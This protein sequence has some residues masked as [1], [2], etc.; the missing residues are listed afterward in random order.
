MSTLT[1]GQILDYLRSRE[2][3]MASLLQEIMAIES[4]TTNKAAVDQL[5]AFLAQH[6]RGMGAAVEILPQVS[7]GDVIRATWNAGDGGIL[8]LCH[9]DTVWD[10]GTI[11]AD[12][13][14]TED[15]RIYGP[16]S[17]D[18]KG[19]IVVTLGAIEALQALGG[20]PDTPITL[21]INTDEET[22]SEASAPI[23]EAEARRHRVVF[24]MEPAEDGAYKTSR[25]GMSQYQ[26]HI[27]GRATH[28]GANH[29]EG[30]NAI[31]ELAR[32]ILTI[33]GFTDYAAGT[34]TNVGI[35]QGGTRSNVVPA[36]A[37]A[38]V[39]SR[40]TSQARQQELDAKMRALKPHHPEAQIE[41]TGGIEAPPLER[42]PQI[43]A[44]FAQA[45]AIAREIGIDLREIAVG[46]GSDGN[47]TAALG[48][49]TLDG[50][51]VVGAGGHAINEYAVIASL[52]ERAAI[53]AAMLRS[54]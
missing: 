14:R 5:A 16:G 31:E 50:M 48:V 17:M 46:G 39:D 4:P 44:L 1:P 18:M 11:H 3:A 22:G 13:V 49:P 8:L 24:V 12:W 52:P 21:L 36:Q 34:T 7:V 35:V 54:V 19:G 30:V 23:I 42:I 43:A 47:R 45:Q 9:M 40:A 20:L 37:W 29:V 2:A 27:T 53:L 41:V 51:G 10:L 26:V 28:A 6:L 38:H 15:G 33:Q 32:Q 25:K